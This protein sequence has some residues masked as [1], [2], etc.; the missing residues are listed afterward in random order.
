MTNGLFSRLYAVVSGLAL[1]GIGFAV[2]YYLD[3][4]AGRFGPRS[5]MELVALL[6][7]SLFFLGIV[8]AVGGLLVGEKIF[9]P[10]AILFTGLLMLIVGAFP[11]VYT[12]W[13]TGDRPNGEAAGMLGTILF[14]IVGVP[15]LFLTLLGAW[16]HH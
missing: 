12:P 2:L 14:L 1:A 13:L 4:H 5:P 3:A 9:S 15:G 11:W 6:M 7:P 8:I 10:R 16:L